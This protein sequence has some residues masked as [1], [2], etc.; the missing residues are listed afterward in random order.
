MSLSIERREDDL[1]E[2][3]QVWSSDGE[4]LNDFTYRDEAEDFC[5]GLIISG[6]YDRMAVAV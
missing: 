5:D 3:F 2:Y 6:Y 4:L 1:G